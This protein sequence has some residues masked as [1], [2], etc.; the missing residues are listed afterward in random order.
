MVSF[1]KEQPASP[2]PAENTGF[3]VK[4]EPGSASAQ[5]LQLEKFVKQE[6]ESDGIVTP[7]LR[8]TPILGARS[9]H[10]GRQDA[11]WSSAACV[12]GGTGRSPLLLRRNFRVYR[13]VG[14]SDL[15]LP[16]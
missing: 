9:V 4:L 11:T 6:P 3:K 12:G 16:L 1:A 5:R 15:P 10:A 13:L 8:G 7:A 14:M 2:S